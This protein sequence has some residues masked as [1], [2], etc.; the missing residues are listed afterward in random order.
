MQKRLTK[1]FL[2]VGSNH[3]MQGQTES[4]KLYYNNLK[5]RC[6]SDSEKPYIIRQVAL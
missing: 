3:L 2:Y 5:V 4:V 1:N 6:N